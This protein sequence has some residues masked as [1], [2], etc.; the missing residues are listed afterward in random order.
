MSSVSDKRFDFPPVSQVPPCLTGHPT[1]LSKI[2]EPKTKRLEVSL[3]DA[4][5]V[6]C[7]DG[8]I[9]LLKFSLWLLDVRS[10]PR[11]SEWDTVSNAFG[12]RGIFHERLC[13]RLQGVLS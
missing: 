7:V 8:E 9:R 1:F 3:E 4:T 13:Y 11:Q 10:F 2:L 5:L 6:T 12:S